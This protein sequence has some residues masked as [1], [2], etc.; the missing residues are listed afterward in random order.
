MA[1]AKLQRTQSLARPKIRTAS[2]LSHNSI[3]SPYSQSFLRDLQHKKQPQYSMLQI[4]T[5]HKNTFRLSASYFF[6]LPL[7]TSQQ[8]ARNLIN[9]ARKQHNV[10]KHTHI[11]PSSS[12][13]TKLS[14]IKHKQQK[15]RAKSTFIGHFYFSSERV[16]III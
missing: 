8:L 1:F 10:N 2:Q 11:T 9:L 15:N 12:L 3:L 5:I 13:K 6:I 14:L 4:K 7:Y 16:S